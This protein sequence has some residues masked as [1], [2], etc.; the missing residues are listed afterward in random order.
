MK[1]KKHIILASVT[2][3]LGLI[4]V[5]AAFAV[6]RIIANRMDKS[7]RKALETVVLQ[8]FTCPNKELTN[9]YVKMYEQA[10]P[11][12]PSSEDWLINLDTSGIEEYLREYYGPYFTDSGYA[13][14]EQRF[15]INNHVYNTAMG[16]R[17]TVDNIEISRSNDIKSNY[18]FK[19][20]LSHG[21]EG[22]L[23]ESTVVEGNAQFFEKHG[24]LSY[25]N[26]IDS[27]LHR[28]IWG[29]GPTF[30]N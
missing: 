30:D 22:G 6:P 5:A 26:F 15:M 11:K 29:R 1:A 8:M 28:K 14:F 4:C 25:F 7:N 2:F 21:E 27:E 13:L 9:L 17:I 24:M 18:S 12:N 10:V 3:L 19:A 20:Y 23:M 16:Y